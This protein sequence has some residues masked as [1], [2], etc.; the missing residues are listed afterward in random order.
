MG[1]H[2]NC[3]LFLDAMDKWSIAGQQQGM[4][5]LHS[6]SWCLRA[7]VPV[8]MTMHPACFAFLRAKN[9]QVGMR[10]HSNRVVQSN[11]L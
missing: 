5:E 8:I 10:D 1:H 3:T 11:N 7:I 9:S 4:L 6:T 2:T